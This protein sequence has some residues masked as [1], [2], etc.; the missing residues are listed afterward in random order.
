MGLKRKEKQEAVD[1]LSGQI[2]GYRAAIEDREHRAAQHDQFAATAHKRETEIAAA[3]A[4]GALTDAKAE[5]ELAKVEGDVRRHECAARHERAVGDE[6]ASTLETKKRALERAR[7]EAA[8]AEASELSV[9]SARASTAAGKSLE[10]LVADVAKF[11]DERQATE[12]AIARAQE[13]A[14]SEE[15]HELVHAA[16][17]DGAVW[18]TLDVEALAGLIRR[19]P[20]RPLAVAATLEERRALEATNRD[21]QLVRDAVESFLRTPGG[22][23]DVDEVRRAKLTALPEKLRPE[24]ERRIAEELAARAPRDRESWPRIGQPVENARR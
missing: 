2:D 6:F 21:R 23:P 10:Q 14:E 17:S 22:L 15:D 20:W 5:A 24:A 16:L 11:Q 4:A 8:V 13:L 1:R 7:F 9:R 19:G 12:A 18:P 3:V